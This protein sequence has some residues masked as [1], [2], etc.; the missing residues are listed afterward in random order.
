L[1]EWFEK[2]TPPQNC[3]LVTFIGDSNLLINTFYEI[4]PHPVDGVPRE[5]D[6]PHH[7]TH[8]PSQ[9]PPASEQRG[10]TLER[11]KDFNLEPWPGS[12]LDCLVC[13]IVALKTRYSHLPRPAFPPRRLCHLATALGVTPYVV[14]GGT[15]VEPFV[16]H[17]I[18]AI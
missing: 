14:G 1:I 15:N 10:N 7:Q 12:G 11:F 3:R 17:A 5:D 4:Q 18:G 9:V 2:S 16:C 8:P 6:E 13:A